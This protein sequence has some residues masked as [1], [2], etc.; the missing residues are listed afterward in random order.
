MKAKPERPA[1]RGPIR[2]RTSGRM[3]AIDDSQED[4]E[5]TVID[6]DDPATSK[7][8]EA[9]EAPEPESGDDE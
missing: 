1:P 5:S 4:S 9:G 3:L 7:P 6:F 2:E 8:A